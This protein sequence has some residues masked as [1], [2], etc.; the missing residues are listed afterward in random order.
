MGEQL[1][2]RS[3]RRAKHLA[4]S[5]LGELRRK[6]AENAMVSPCFQTPVSMV[7]PAVTTALWMVM[8]G[9]NVALISQGLHRDR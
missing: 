8:S 9:S 2:V 3:G 7:I 6:E 5:L 4:G 1:Y